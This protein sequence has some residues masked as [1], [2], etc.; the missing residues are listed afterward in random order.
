MTPA[1]DAYAPLIRRAGGA[2]R[3]VALQPPGWR[4]EREALEAA[5]D[6]EDAGDHLQQPAQPDRPP[7]RRGGAGSGGDVAREHDLI[8]IS[9]EVWEHLLLDGQDFVPLA[10]LPGMARADDQD[11]AR[12]GRSSR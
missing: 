7:V 5:V 6:R 8:V 10:T 1:Y 11:A 3:E 4:I 2:V 9:D 12:R